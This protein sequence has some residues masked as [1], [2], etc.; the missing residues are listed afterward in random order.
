MRA[1]PHTI[2]VKFWTGSKETTMEPASYDE[3]I[4]FKNG[5]KRFEAEVLPQNRAMLTVF[6]HSGLSPNH[7]YEDGYIYVTMPLKDGESWRPAA[8]MS[9]KATVEKNSVNASRFPADRSSSTSKINPGKLVLAPPALGQ[10][11]CNARARIVKVDVLYRECLQFA[12]DTTPFLPTHVGDF[13]C[14]RTR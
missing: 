13:S 12:Q 10:R 6:E 5:V 11:H 3:H 7:K 1:K 8:A 2:E 9:P 14:F 4:T